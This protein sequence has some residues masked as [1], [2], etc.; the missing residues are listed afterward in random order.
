MAP[1]DRRKRI[2]DVFQLAVQMPTEERRRFV[3]RECRGDD[4]L[5]R[6]VEA[7]LTEYQSSYEKS[8]EIFS[9]KPE[10]GPAPSVAGQYIGK[11]K[12]KEEIGR[13]GLGRVYSAHDPGFN[14]TVAIK[15]M[16]APGDPD[17]VQG[18][19]RDAPTVP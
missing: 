1:T 9:T 7:L 18:F 3:E 10:T 6:E 19:R 12:V 5:T 13:G 14:R 16:S 15:V 17:L 8:S 2:T 4:T 11:Y